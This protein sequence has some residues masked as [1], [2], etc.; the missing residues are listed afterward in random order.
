MKPIIAAA[1]ALIVALSAPPAEAGRFVE[2]SKVEGVSVSITDD[3]CTAS[4]LLDDAR[5]RWPDDAR[6]TLSI[7]L[8]L[9]IVG[10]SD[11]S[12]E[13]RGFVA[14]G[15][16]PTA[17]LSTLTDDAYLFEPGDAEDDNWSRTLAFGETRGRLRL[18]MAIN[19]DASAGQSELAVDSIDL[20]IE[21]CGPVD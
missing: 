19:E 2:L 11:V 10:V 15:G 4:I 3:A 18:V 6:T 20:A 8:P 16:E 12:V 5:V 9:R 1:G 7:A 14:G 17:L 13:A 21:N